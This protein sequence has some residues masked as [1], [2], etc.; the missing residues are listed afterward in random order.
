MAVATIAGRYISPNPGTDQASTVF[1]PRQ[2]GL[3]DC[4]GDPGLAEADDDAIGHHDILTEAGDDA[5]G[6]HDV[7]TEAGDDALGHHDLLTK[8]S[9]DAVGDHDVIET[10]GEAA[11]TEAKGGNEST[12]DTDRPGAP[13]WGKRITKRC[14]GFESENG[15]LANF[16]FETKYQGLSW[17]PSI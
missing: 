11:E 4:G 14:S 12:E 17:S 5:I 7:L 6:P 15:L 10:L 2:P 8:T 9:D 3:A 13:P 16:T 1:A